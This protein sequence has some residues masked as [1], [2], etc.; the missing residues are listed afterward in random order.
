MGFFSPFSFCIVYILNVWGSRKVVKNGI[1][2][3]NKKYHL[4]KGKQRMT[5]SLTGGGGGGYS[6]LA[7]IVGPQI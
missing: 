5:L 7:P 2:M 6:P 1:E 4:S 3:K